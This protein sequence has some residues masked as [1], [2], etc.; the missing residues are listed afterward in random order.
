MNLELSPKFTNAGLA[1]VAA[2][3]GNNENVYISHIAIGNGDGGAGAGGYVVDRTETTLVN[4]LSRAVVAGYQL[5][6]SQFTVEVLLGSAVPFHA[7]E[8]GY[9]LSDGTLLA[10]WSS[11]EALV[12]INNL[13]LKLKMIF[14]VGE[15]YVDVIN[16]LVEAA[17]ALRLDGMNRP[18]ADIDWDNNKILNLANAVDDGDAMN[19]GETK[20]L[21]SNATAINRQNISANYDAVSGD[22]LFVFSTIENIEIPLPLNPVEYDRIT[23]NAEGG[24]PFQIMRNGQTIENI[25]EDL[26]INRTCKVVFTFVGGTWQTAVSAV[27]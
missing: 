24:H 6:E 16:F 11:N 14:T 17:S 19:L 8:V 9:F 1:A 20:R 12:E 13:S 26:L 10:V 15:M 3:I 2:A 23:I 25:S 22:E 7:Y 18:T 27:N 5:V 4:E 21:I